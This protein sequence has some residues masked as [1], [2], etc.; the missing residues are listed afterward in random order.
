MEIHHWHRRVAPLESLPHFLHALY[1]L[2]P[3]TAELCA[4]H[5]ET[6]VFLHCPCVRVL[7]LTP[8][9]NIP[10]LHLEEVTCCRKVSCLLESASP[11]QGQLCPMTGPRGAQRHGL[12]PWF[13]TLRALCTWPRPLLPLTHTS[14]PPSAPPGF[15]DPSHVQL[16]RTLTHWTH[17]TSVCRSPLSSHPH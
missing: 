5:C 1:N 8:E 16:L 4:K 14:P 11:L 9:Q 6:L 10:S 2:S 17:C 3:V 13:T 12:L 15:L 7:G